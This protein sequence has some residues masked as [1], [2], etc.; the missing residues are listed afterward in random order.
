MIASIVG[1]GV[2][3]VLNA[4]GHWVAEAIAGIMVAIGSVLTDITKLQVGQ[5]Y[6]AI[7]G[8]VMI[9]AAVLGVGIVG[10]KAAQGALSGRVRQSLSGVAQVGGGLFAAAVLAAVL[11]LVQAALASTASF[12]AGGITG[13]NAAG[14][15]TKLGA[16][17]A[18]LGV[19]IIAS[20]GALLPILGG[21]V[22]LAALGIVTALIVS[23]ALVYIVLA[24]CP[25]LFV[26]GP[27]AMARALEVLIVA[28]STP[29]LIT[30]M[31]AIGIALLAD[32]PLTVSGAITSTIV[33]LGILV[34]G[35]VSPF[36]LIRLLPH[37]AIQE[38]FGRMEGLQGTASQHATSVP[39]QGKAISKGISSAFSS[40]DSEGAGGAANGAASA[41]SSGPGVAS[42]V[43]G[44]AATAA[45]GGAAAAAG[46]G[47][48]AAGAAGGAGAAANGASAA[49]AAGAAASSQPPPPP[50]DGLLRPPSVDE[51]P[52]KPTADP[53]YEPP[54]PPGGEQ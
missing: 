30:L 50:T 35:T 21:I 28:L 12:V 52:P 41:G 27:K 37:P 31:L 32:G 17:T 6:W 46:A 34:M 45:T 49:S 8:R 54:E 10:V 48:A 51:E 23:V 38:H 36:V 42:T 25:I 3:Y 4:I 40:P 39:A 5:S 24:L 18:G 11:P 29:A 43:A 53:R 20:D 22:L 33:G 15:A 19:G 7:Y 2:N 47:G 44:A 16:L 13:V 9:V 14:L 1:D 26:L